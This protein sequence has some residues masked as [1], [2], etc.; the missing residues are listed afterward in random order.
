VN[1]KENM[2]KERGEGGV[3]TFNISLGLAC[4]K[5]M[6]YFVELGQIWVANNCGQGSDF[7]C[8]LRE[9]KCEE[10]CIIVF[11]GQGSFAFVFGWGI[12]L[13]QT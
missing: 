6:Q 12:A 9:W 8:D 11:F 7:A 10:R 13:V 3:Q 4:K 5:G 1:R 2:G